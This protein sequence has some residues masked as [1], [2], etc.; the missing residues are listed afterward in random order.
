MEKNIYIISLLALAACSCTPEYF[1]EHKVSVNGYDGPIETGLEVDLGLSAKWSGYNV[2]ADAPEQAGCFYAWGETSPKQEFTEQGYTAFPG[3]E[4]LTPECDIAY[5]TYGYGWHMPSPEDYLELAEKCTAT[6]V[7]YH[8]VN[9][10]VVTSRVKG[11]EG[12]SIFFPA[13]GYAA[14][15][16]V[17]YAGEYAVYWTDASAAEGN[18]R[19]QN[20]FFQKDSL[21]LNAPPRGAGGLAWCGY[22]V[23]GVKKFFFSTDGEDV[24]VKKDETSCK[25]HVN[26]NA[27]WTASVSAGATISP[28]SGEGSAEITVSFPENTSVDNKVYTV[29]VTDTESSERY[30]FKITQF[31]V[32]PDFEI[33]GA[34][35]EDI[36]WDATSAS[37]RIRTA[38]SVA[39]TAAVR[40]GGHIVEGAS[41]SPASGTGS[42]DVA[43]TLPTSSNIRGITA[44]SV[45]FTANDSRIPA[46]LST[47]AYTVNQGRCPVVPFGASW[48]ESFFTGLE[49]AYNADKNATQYVVENVTV[50]PSTVG[51]LAFVSGQAVKNKVSL[52]FTVKES[53]TGYVYF[54]KLYNGATSAKGPAFRVYASDGSTP[55]CDIV[56]HN[57]ASKTTEKDVVSPDLTVEA[58]DIVRISMTSTD[59]F[60]IYGFEWRKKETE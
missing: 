59:S 52:S 29:T 16:T 5:R 18:L 38:S 57:V 50:T 53:G 9:G 32:T 36:D 43:I 19:A 30:E 23:R 3:G 54:T 20:A 51:K 11:Y 6:Y 49:A 35:S 39:W 56:T 8:G 33:D 26:T 1:G 31:G 14:G 7:C 27:R 45:E 55:K 28:A 21:R 40:I 44:Y 37:C 47:V 17:N 4:S 10:W 13:C 2:G 22:S 48:G 24:S 34:L 58:G 46:E 41:L 42:A 15:S 12:K 60:S 25:F